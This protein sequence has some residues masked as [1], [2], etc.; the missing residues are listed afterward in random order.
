V[1]LQEHV[2]PLPTQPRQSR[3]QPLPAGVRSIGK[4][5]PEILNRYG[6]SLDELD[7]SQPQP[8]TTTFVS[9]VP[10]SNSVLEPMAAVSS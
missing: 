4:I 7:G 2:L 10:R 3:R 6:L 9:I 8:A 5:M 1:K